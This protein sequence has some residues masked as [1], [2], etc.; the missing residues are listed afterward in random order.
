LLK[1]YKIILR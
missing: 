1:Q